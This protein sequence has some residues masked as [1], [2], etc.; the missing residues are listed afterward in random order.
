MLG[1]Q[2]I[3]HVITGLGIGGAETAMLQLLRASAASGADHVVFTLSTKDDLAEAVR[4][5]GTRVI[6][7]RISGTVDILRSVMKVR[8]QIK[9]ERPA[10]LMTWMHHADLFG[11]L[12]KCFSM[13]VPLVW[14]IRCS[15][16]EIGYLP[17]RHLRMVKLLAKLSW[18]PATIVSNSHAGRQEHIEVGYR[19]EGWR[20]LPN[21]FDTENFA[22]N[23]DAA[24][25]MREE[26]GFSPDAFLIGL[27][28]RYHPMKGFDLFIRAAG[29]LARIE[30]EAHFVLVGSDVDHQNLELASMIAEDGLE[31]RISLIG[32]RRDIP[33]VMAML[34]VVVSTS[35]SEGFPNV[36]GE[37]MAC[38][39]P[40]VVTD[41][42]DSAV[43]L[44]ET[45][46]VI[47]SGAEDE[48]VSALQGLIQM[49]PKAFEN[50]QSLTRSRIVK[51][52]SRSEMA[53]RYQEL[54][55]EFTP[56]L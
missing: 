14:N 6:P 38:G 13:S 28:A 30:Q 25:E 33:R 29:R 2:V 50:L 23:P 44:G 21:G 46:K 10:L 43:L 47:V 45:G 3:F 26:L 39:T 42:G 55:D 18:L 19:T 36:I 12:L 48:L 8:S 35:T 27:V 49:P 34:D 52:F 56:S 15:K 20:V 7:L 54:F 17:K 40:C 37:A 5:T 53:R 31:N 51:H 24:L 9:A 4:E 11:V 32:P 16:L 22:P 41:V 1:K